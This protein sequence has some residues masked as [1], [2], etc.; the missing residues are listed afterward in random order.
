MS[1]ETR[2]LSRIPRK[3]FVNLKRW[4]S[5]LKESRSD[6]ANYPRTKGGARPVGA[7]AVREKMATG[8]SGCCNQLRL[9]PNIGK[10]PEAMAGCACHF[11]EQGFSVPFWLTLRFPQEDSSISARIAC[12]SSVAETTGKSTTRAHPKA[13]MHCAEVILRRAWRHRESRHRQYAGTASNN[14]ARLSSN[15]IE[16]VLSGERG[17]PSES[18]RQT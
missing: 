8:R 13:K 9:I 4:I 16:I 5:L 18:D 2:P 17:T 14:H 12:R 3:K 7:A 1:S 10:T 6:T 15:S 11:P